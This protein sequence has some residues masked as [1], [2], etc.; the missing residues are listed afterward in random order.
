MKLAE[1][2]QRSRRM[3]CLEKFHTQLLEYDGKLI[4]EQLSEILTLV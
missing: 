4:N 2:S 3:N 1:S